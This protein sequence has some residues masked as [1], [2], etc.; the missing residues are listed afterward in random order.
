MQVL[1]RTGTQIARELKIP[2]F[3]EDQL[4]DPEINVRL[5][6]W[7]LSKLLE[8][9]GGKVHL[10]LAAYNAGPHAVRKWMANAPSSTEDEFVENI[11]YWETRN[12]VIRVIS[13]AQ[14]YRT[15]YRPPEKPVQP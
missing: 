11:P 2:R 6:S 12:Y 15:L 14:V 7:Y 13:S 1:P 4:F 3:S 9:F 5:G 8:E 10:A